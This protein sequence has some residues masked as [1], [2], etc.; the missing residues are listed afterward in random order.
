MAAVWDLHAAERGVI[1][2][3]DQDRPEEGTPSRE[4]QQQLRFH[5][6]I[7]EELMAAAYANHVNISHTPGEFVIT[8]AQIPPL[9]DDIAR[10]ET[11]EKGRLE[12]IAVANVIVSHAFLPVIIEVFQKNLD[13]VK[14]AEP[15][16]GEK[17]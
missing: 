7:P 1:M 3:A 15:K 13:K 5:I 2:M 17:D 12:A 16:K 9:R 10:E 4:E 11:L 14:E 8:F 6:R